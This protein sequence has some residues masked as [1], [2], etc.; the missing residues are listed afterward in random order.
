M[1][2]SFSLLHI[3]S[4]SSQINVLF[5]AFFYFFFINTYDKGA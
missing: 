5:V 2:S 1:F 4:N 3:Y